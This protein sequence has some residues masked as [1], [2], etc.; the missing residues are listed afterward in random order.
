MTR[1]LLRALPVLPTT[2]PVIDKELRVVLSA[3]A[4][5]GVGGQGLNLAHMMEAYAGAALATFCRGRGAPPDVVGVPELKVQG[6]M[7]RVPL[8]NRRMDLLTLVSDVQ[9]DRHVARHLGNVDLFQG[10]VGQAATSL[11]RAREL[12][13]PTVLDVVNT[14]VDD[15]AVHVERECKKFGVRPFIHPAMRWRIRREYERATI[16]R[17]MSDTARRT[18]LERGVSPDR[19]FTATPPCDVEGSPVA[20]H[21]DPVFRV[22]FVGLVAPWK[23]FH[24]LVDAFDRAALRESELVLWGGTGNRGTSQWLKRKMAAND[25]IVLRPQ[26]VRALGF[27]EV[28]G[29]MSVLVHPSLAD[30]FA[31]VVAEAMGCGVPVIVT[32]N[33]GAAD[34]VVEGVNGY[35]VPPGDADAIADRLRFLA[36]HRSLIPKMGAEARL[37]ARR[38]TRDRFRQQL[39]EPAL[40]ITRR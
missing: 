7:S 37:A 21:D 39:L 26:S 29:A 12:G 6:L 28:Y 34:L 32:S 17:V 15:F 33:T 23:G 18:F 3:N 22:G 9:F 5:P 2:E 19:V 31:Y 30:G 25:R 4:H 13:V 27:A 11:R 24:Y 16:I 20:A 40:A 10:A 8:V 35:V 38:L 1:C 14:H 36:S